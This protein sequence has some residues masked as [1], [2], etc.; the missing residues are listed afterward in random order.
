MLLSPTVK[1]LSKSAVKQL[2]LLQLNS[3]RA[4]YNNHRPLAAAGSDAPARGIFWS[5]GAMG[6]RSPLATG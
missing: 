5:L 4:A 2:P 1:S 6:H 3:I